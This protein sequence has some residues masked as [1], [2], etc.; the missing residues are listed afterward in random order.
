[1]IS[2]IPITSDRETA[3]TPQV[4]EPIITIRIAD[5]VAANSPDVIRVD[6]KVVSES[7][8]KRNKKGLKSKAN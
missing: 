4:S 7:S 3:K 5:F 6:I 8:L 1:M 2:D